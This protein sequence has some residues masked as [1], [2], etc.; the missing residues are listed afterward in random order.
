M[1]QAFN[2][3][4]LQKIDTQLDQINGR[5][6]EIGHILATDETLRQAEEDLKTA[7]NKLF[8]MQQ[9]LKQKEEEVLAQRIK[10]ETAESSLYG[11]K[12]RNPKELQDLQVDVASLKKRLS[13]LE[14]EQLDIMVAV[15][16]SETEFG[17][18][19]KA[20]IQAQADHSNRSA[21]LVGEQSQLIKSKDNLI[22]ERNPLL[23]SVVPEN[24]AIY[25]SLREQK[26][27]VAVV[28]VEDESCSA[29]GT[30][31]R[32]VEI[33]AA[34]SP[35]KIAFCSSCNRILYAG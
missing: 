35:Q 25:Q 26:K 16:L 18:T 29:C 27:G 7:K 14:D 28:S 21:S 10:I 1:N 22:A 9:S 24:L 12:V 19:Q 2:L 34:R 31:I 8:I 5:L 11:G 23:N 3:F 30:T 17:Q 20:L 33:Q 13:I 4:R 6:A 15:E 32:P